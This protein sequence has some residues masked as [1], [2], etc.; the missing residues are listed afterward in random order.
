MPGPIPVIVCPGLDGSASEFAD[1]EDLLA[2]VL[3]FRF[4]RYPDNDT[5]DVKGLASMVASKLRKLPKGKRLLAGCSFGGF[6]AMQTALRYPELV[7]GLCLIATFNHDPAPISEALGVALARVLPKSTTKT[8]ARV[9][10]RKITGKRMAKSQH[11]RFADA[12]DAID[13]FVM[14][15]RVRLFQGWDA[16]ERL[17]EIAVPV[18]VVYATRDGISGTKAQIQGWAAIPNARVT[19]VKSGH[20]LPYAK[21]K[22]LGKL[23]LDWVQRVTGTAQ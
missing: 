5:A 21:P 14:S 11:K 2:P 4:A 23:M 22:E 6:V 3:E 9:L 20:V 8:V 13:P 10:A 1:L 17:T 15:A 7:D 19:G 16:R 18:E 12:I